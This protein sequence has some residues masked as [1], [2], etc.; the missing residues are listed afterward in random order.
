MSCL[1]NKL[2]RIVAL[3]AAVPR[4]LLPRVYGHIAARINIFKVARNVP[5]LPFSHPRIPIYFCAF[6]HDTTNSISTA[7]AS[8][9]P[10]PA[11]PRTPTPPSP[12]A[13]A[14]DTSLRINCIPP[15]V[16]STSAY[17]QDSLSPMRERVPGVERFKSTNTMDPPGGASTLSVD[18]M[19]NMGPPPPPSGSRNPFNFQ[20]QTIKDT[21]AL[22]KP[23]S[24]PNFIISPQHDCKAENQK[25]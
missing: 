14:E 8:S 18:N 4:Y 2:S 23:V 6:S 10:I 13:N 21:P 9:L 22:V 25:L 17:N 16:R 1:R 15:H 5:S 19:G 11:P 7:M 24:D 20:T 3:I 12:I